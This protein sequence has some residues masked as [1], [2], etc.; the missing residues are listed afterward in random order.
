[1]HQAVT[2]SAKH[3]WGAI[4]YFWGL[5]CFNCRDIYSAAVQIALENWKYFLNKGDVLVRH[6]L[7]PDLNRACGQTCSLIASSFG[8]RL[9]SWLEISFPVMDVLFA[10]SCCWQR[11]K[12]GLGGDFV[13]LYGSR[14][15]WIHLRVEGQW[16]V[17][18]TVGQEWQTG[19]CGAAIGCEL[20]LGL[21][22]TRSGIGLAGPGCQAGVWSGLRIW[23]L[24]AGNVGCCSDDSC[25]VLHRSLRRICPVEI[26]SSHLKNSGYIFF[27]R[28]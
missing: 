17:E 26:C 18:R 14:C 2:P 6:F 25:S 20:R 23:N 16:A 12:L 21:S 13:G 9:C 24:V 19:A 5:Y 10:W 22:G 11:L 3:I 28:I 1:M 15:N 4:I 27:I 8:P 7:R